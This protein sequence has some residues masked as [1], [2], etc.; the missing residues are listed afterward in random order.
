MLENCQGLSGWFLLE[1][2]WEVLGIKAVGLILLL[3]T[4]V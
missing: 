3:L 2:S 1:D 4:L